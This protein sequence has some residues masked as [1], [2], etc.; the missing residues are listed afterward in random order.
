[1]KK[2]F[3]FFLAMMML[4]SF[5][6]AEDELPEITFRGAR[7]GATLGEVK[8]TLECSPHKG[9]AWQYY[10]VS[11]ILNQKIGLLNVSINENTAAQRVILADDYLLVEDVAGYQPNYTSAFFIRP[12]ADGKLIAEDDSAIFYAGIYTFVESKEQTKVLYKDIAS[13]LTSLYG[14]PQKDGSRLYW[15]GKDSTEIDLIL[16]GTQFVRLSYVWTEAQ[17]LIDTAYAVPAEPAPDNSSNRN[18]L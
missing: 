10:N 16:N 1:M 15:R 4:F 6:I 12:V 13:K 18:G 5:A 8:E 3:A 11:D 2:V 9:S 7:L 14:E 17:E